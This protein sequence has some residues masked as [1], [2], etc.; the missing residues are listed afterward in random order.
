MD[1]LAV[2]RARAGADRYLLLENDGLATGKRERARHREADDARADDDRID[3]LDRAVSFHGGAVAEK[4]RVCQT[5]C[6][7]GSTVRTSRRN[8]AD[9][10]T[11]GVEA[12]VGVRSPIRR[13]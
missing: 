12:W 5:R 11:F 2:A 3:L 4:P 7:L 9:E 13:P 10:L 1:D 8:V 6:C